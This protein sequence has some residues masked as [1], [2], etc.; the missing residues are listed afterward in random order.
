MAKHSS[1]IIVTI[2]V[3]TNVNGLTSSG[4]DCIHGYHKQELYGME[5]YFIMLSLK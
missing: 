2:F 1:H 3:P 5:M 4:G